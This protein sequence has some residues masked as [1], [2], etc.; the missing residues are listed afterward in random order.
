[1]DEGERIDH[2]VFDSI[3]DA[4]A[5]CKKI[6]DDDLNAM[7]RSN[8]TAAELYSCYTLFGASPF[9]VPVDHDGQPVG[10][11]ALTYA[12]K[13]SRDLSG[14]PWTNKMTDNIVTVGL[15]YEIRPW[16]DRMLAIQNTNNMEPGVCR[17]PNLRTFH[18]GCG[19]GYV[20]HHLLLQSCSL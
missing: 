16:P 19:A 7:C 14:Y 18:I 5:A 11:S 12:K 1:M 8:K 3:D 20:G 9:A 10:F 15:N 13:R 17:A 6:I 4:V 2:G